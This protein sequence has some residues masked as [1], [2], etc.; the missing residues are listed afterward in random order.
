M[1]EKDKNVSKIVWRMENEVYPT[2]NNMAIESTP[3]YTYR[4]AVKYIPIYKFIFS[5]VI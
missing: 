5:I 2:T 1:N 3:G 4:M